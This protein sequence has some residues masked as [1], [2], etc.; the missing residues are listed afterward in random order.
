MTSDDFAKTC[1]CHIDL[2]YFIELA[3]VAFRLILWIPEAM[4]FI[5]RIQ[6]EEEEVLFV[7]KYIYSSSGTLIYDRTA[8]L[9]W[10]PYSFK[11][12][13]LWCIHKNLTMCHKLIHMFLSYLIEKIIKLAIIKK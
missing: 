5:R 12:Y 8:I 7:V 11:H 13:I 10:V 9:C 3:F 4:S 1:L 6:K 2:R